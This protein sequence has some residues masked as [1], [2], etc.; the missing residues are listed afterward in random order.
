MNVQ[1]DFIE[2]MHG[3]RLACQHKDLVEKTP[4]ETDHNLRSQALRNGI[5]IIGFSV[6]EHF[7]RSR[8]G[9]LL[10]AF[11]QVNTPFEDLPKKIREIATK[12]AIKG[13]LK[14]MNFND[15][16]ILFTQTEAEIIASSK[17]PIYQISQYSIGWDNSNL[18]VADVNTI[19]KSFSI[20]S[21]WSNIDVLSSRLDLTILSSK[22]A[23][24]N[25][26]QRRH[27]AAHN[28]Y[29]R[30]Q[31][32]DLEN[33]VRE[34]YAIALGFDLLLSTAYYKIFI[35]DYRFL[36]NGI[37]ITDKDVSWRM[38]IQDG[39]KWKEYREQGSRAVK[40]AGTKEELWPYA[41]MRA[42]N[43]NEFLLSMDSDGF[44]SKW[45]MPSIL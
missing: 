38:I 37:K 18:N 11:N 30:I 20:D 14:R 35:G 15:D 22:E 25:A 10:L 3:F 7:I 4:D 32:T 27:D 19:L 12:G 41:L 24:Y 16:P 45:E 40:T 6:L 33:F 29:A 8:T 34:A 5:A 9:E 1:S 2:G 42:K 44:P 21:G 17:D 39:N 43:N 13:I 23:F 28:V 26:A 31:P 36:N